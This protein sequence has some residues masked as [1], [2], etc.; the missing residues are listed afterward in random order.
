ML[1][2]Q[3]TDDMQFFLK[4]KLLTHLTHKEKLNGCFFFK[5]FAMWKTLLMSIRTI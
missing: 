4:F 2:L 1:I 3:Q 5:K